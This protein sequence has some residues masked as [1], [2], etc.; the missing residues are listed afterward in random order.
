MPFPG[1]WELLLFASGLVDL[2]LY[3]VPN[4]GYVALGAMV[5]CLS[6]MASVRSLHIGFHLI[7]P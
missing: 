6:A 2:R 5:S 1:L 3:N 4:E 7:L